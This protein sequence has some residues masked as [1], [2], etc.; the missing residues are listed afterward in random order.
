MRP[1]SLDKLAERIRLEQARQAATTGVN[2]PALYADRDGNIG[3]AEPDANTVTLSRLTEEPMFSPTVIGTG[4]SDEWLAH[5]R[6]VVRTKLPPSTVEVPRPGVPGWAYTICDR[7]G[8]DYTIWVGYDLTQGLWF[9][10]LVDPPR[11][12]LR[13]P[14]GAPPTDH[15]LHLFVDGRICLSRSIGYPDLERTYARTCLWCLGA[16]SY[17]LG[18][19]F[20]FSAD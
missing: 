6:D 5:Q 2:L 7:F 19:G 10:Y 20:V 17:R 9:A 11:A 3:V 14:G 4:V 12:A 18:Y 16:S 15:D 8:F 13:P 1:E